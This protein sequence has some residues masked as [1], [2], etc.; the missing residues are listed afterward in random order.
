M[1]KIYITGCAKLMKKCVQCRELIESKIPLCN[2]PQFSSNQN[3]PQLNQNS[4][5]CNTTNS[6]VSK[7]KLVE[8]EIKLCI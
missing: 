7:Q 1:K 6:L 4:P 3:N 5:I 2:N 8:I